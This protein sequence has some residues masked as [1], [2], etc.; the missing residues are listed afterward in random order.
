MEQMLTAGFITDSKHARNAN[1]PSMSA[2]CTRHKSAWL[3][4]VTNPFEPQIVLTPAV[5]MAI[6]GNWQ[7]HSLTLSER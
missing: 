7:E 6:G 2:D 3:H 4:N 5:D 1:A